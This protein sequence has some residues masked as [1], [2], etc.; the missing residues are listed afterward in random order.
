M[1]SYERF[2]LIIWYNLN[3]DSSLRYRFSIMIL[4]HTRLSV[5]RR[6]SKM[7]QQKSHTSQNQD[8]LNRTFGPLKL[9]G[10]IQ[11]NIGYGRNYIT[12]S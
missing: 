7:F 11:Y 8:K 10:I 12:M 1:A 3:S 4:L 9:L 5:V 2:D 6:Y